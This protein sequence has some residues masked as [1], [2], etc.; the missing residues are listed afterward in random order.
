MRGDGV[1]SLPMT[2]AERD[3]KISRL[4]KRYFDNE[5]DLAVLLNSRHEL[6][7]E[8]RG[9]ATA[10]E[11]NQFKSPFFIKPGRTVEQEL[12]VLVDQLQHALAEKEQMEGCLK[13]AGYEHVLI[14]LADFAT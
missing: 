9:M 5:R 1:E 10:L 8:L 6:A 11:Q 13:K 7:E 4:L 14:P 2:D 12:R 3:E